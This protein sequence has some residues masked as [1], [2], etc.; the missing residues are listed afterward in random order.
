MI[1]EVSIDRKNMYQTY[2][3]YV[4]IVMKEYFKQNKEF[5]NK[6]KYPPSKNNICEHLIIFSHNTSLFAFVNFKN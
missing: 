4:F 3:F 1:T 5:E 6:A 2:L